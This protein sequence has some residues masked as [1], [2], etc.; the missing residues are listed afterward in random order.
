MSEFFQILIESNTVNFII[1]LAL[2]LIV[3][4]KLNINKYIDTIRNEIQNYVKDSENEKEE[5]EKSLENINEKIRHLPE[6][7]KKIKKSTDISVKSINEKIKSDIENQKK[8]IQNNADRIMQL[9]IKKFKS[10]LT[11]ILS[12]KSIEIAKDNAKE[13]LNNNKEL[14]NIYID[15]AIEEIDRISL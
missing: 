14:H 1:V 12:E 3:S 5:A 8:D 10:K 7:I 9:E 2:I 6:E 11:N 4:K 13:Q 15:K